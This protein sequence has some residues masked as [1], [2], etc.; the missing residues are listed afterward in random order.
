MLSHTGNDKICH[1][2]SAEHLLIM[3]KTGCMHLTRLDQFAHAPNGD[4][5][6]SCRRLASIAHMR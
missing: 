6:A 5:N 3:L 2:I 4:P 1:F